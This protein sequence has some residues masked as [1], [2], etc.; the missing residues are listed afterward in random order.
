MNE[1]VHFRLSAFIITYDRH[2]APHV[3]RPTL[4]ATLCSRFEPYL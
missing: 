3:R 2:P 1:L 4:Y